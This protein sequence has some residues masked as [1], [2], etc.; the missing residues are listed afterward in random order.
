MNRVVLVLL[1]WIY[2][3][4][5]SRVMFHRTGF[6]MPRKFLKP[7]HGRIAFS[8]LVA[9]KRK[10]R[11]R[12]GCTWK[13]V[14]DLQK[15]AQ[16]SPQA[17]YNITVSGGTNQIVAGNNSGSATQTVTIEQERS[18]AFQLLDEI[19]KQLDH[20]DDSFS[21]ATRMEAV[22]YAKLIRQELKKPEPNRNLISAGFGPIKQDRFDCEHRRHSN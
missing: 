20:D 12:A 2:L 6:L 9:Q 7:A 11:V 10:S 13:R 14:A 22:T 3:A 8:P 15:K 21:E 5:K 16:E 18:R 19:E 17:Y 4:N 1:T